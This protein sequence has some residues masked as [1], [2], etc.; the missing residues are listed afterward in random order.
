[1]EFNDAYEGM[2][3]YPTEK[4]K[5][6]MMVEPFNLRRDIRCI[7]VITGEY[8]YIKGRTAHLF[9]EGGHIINYTFENQKVTYTQGS[10]KRLLDFDI[11]I[12]GTKVFLVY[13]LMESG[14]C[15]GYKL[16]L[17]NNNSYTIKDFSTEEA[18]K[19]VNKFQ[20]VNCTVVKTETTEWV[21]SLGGDTIE[22]ELKEIKEARE[23][24]ETFY[25]NS[26][27]M[28]QE[29]ER[30]KQYLNEIEH[31]DLME[32]LK[33]YEDKSNLGDEAIQRIRKAVKNISN[34]KNNA[35]VKMV[36]TRALL[37]TTIGV[38]LG[39]VFGNLGNALGV[40][41]FNDINKISI[42]KEVDCSEL[43][44]DEVR[45]ILDEADLITVKYGPLR[46]TGK[47]CVD[48]VHIA[49]LNTKMI[50]IGIHTSITTINGE[51]VVQSDQELSLLIRNFTISNDDGSAF[52]MKQKVKLGKKIMGITLENSE[53][54]QIKNIKMFSILS[55]E[56]QM[57]DKD[58]N[59]MYKLTG[60]VCNYTFTVE[61]SNKEGDIDTAEALA[62]MGS[63]RFK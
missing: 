57:V 40:I 47:I 33:I 21:R 61:C 59:E 6:I 51:I 32:I 30:M 18:I 46:K 54:A 11:P 13:R 41:V 39:G 25:N 38:L 20:S 60:E 16:L 50:A 36:V 10:E 2:C 44:A 37:Y 24:I 34:V 53:I 4:I 19:I 9:I 48:N 7:N 52:N 5:Q 63:F 14:K 35:N 12:V 17:L 3:L 15:V 27:H 45:S 22:V 26:K 62:M 55:Q 1:M 28:K 23:E 43:N 58:D 31:L 49:N 56:A 29:A 42:N 8:G